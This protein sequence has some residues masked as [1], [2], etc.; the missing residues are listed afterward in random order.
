MTQL[1]VIFVLCSN[2]SFTGT[3][4]WNSESIRM[5]SIRPIAT[6]LLIDSFEHPMSGVDDLNAELIVWDDNM[7]KRP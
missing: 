1:F 5:A 4:R 6:C 3:V 2:G 7:R